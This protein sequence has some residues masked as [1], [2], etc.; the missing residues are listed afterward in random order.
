[1]GGEVHVLSALIQVQLTEFTKLTPSL[2]A[3]G[4]CTSAMLICGWE[5]ATPL[6]FTND[7]SLYGS[8]GTIPLK[9]L[10]A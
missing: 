8:P 7:S 1:M 5:V 4:T 10:Q 6:V 3:R 9:T 2:G